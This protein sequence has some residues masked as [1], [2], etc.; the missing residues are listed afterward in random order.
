MGPEFERVM[1]GSTHNTIYMDDLR[2]LTIPLPPIEEQLRISA[3]LDHHT[4]RIDQL[5]KK[6]QRLLKLLE[7]KRQAV[8]TQAV[9]KGLD[10]SGEMV[11]SDVEW[12]DEVPA[13]WDIGRVG[14]F[15]QVDLGK[16]LDQK[17]ITGDHLAPYLRN[18]DVQW[19][20]INTRDLPEMDFE[21]GER[22]R[23]GLEP[24][25]VLVCEG[26]E[27]G[28]SAVWEGQ[29]EDCFYQK[30]LHRVRG[31][32]EAQNPYFFTYFMEAAA[33]GG[34]FEAQSDRSTIDHLTEEKLRR[35]PFPS[36]PRD[37]QDRIVSYLN[38]NRARI[39]KLAEKV[40]RGIPL[41]REKRQALITAAVTGQ[42]EVTDWEPPEDEESTVEK[43]EA[44]A[45]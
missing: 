12:L 14:Y 22:E 30:A 21:P 1:Q 28:R 10:P 13:H 45:P 43:A 18:K 25:D 26:G 36:P 6:K 42:I 40:R 9:T 44:I 17:E 11:E 7:E 19:W 23:Y 8:I 31:F 35:L 34:I 16:M 5:I 15:F 20:E 33:K 32:G 3:F 37:E 24:G 2:S 29:R 41:L 27:I 39:E 38:E 4:A